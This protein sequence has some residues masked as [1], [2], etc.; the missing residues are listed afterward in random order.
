[1]QSEKSIYTSQLDTNVRPQDD[2]FGYVNNTWLAAHPI[3]DSETWWGTFM[4]L[5]DEAWANLRTLYEELQGA[6]V[7]LQTI[8]QQARD[9]YYTGMH[10]NEFEQA[11]LDLIRRYLQ[12]IDAVE[13]LSQLSELLGSFD[14]IDVPGLWRVIIDVDDKDASRHIL[15]LKQPRL[16]LPDR[17]YYLDDAQKMKDIRTAYERHSRKVYEHF[18]EL[19]KDADSLWR[20]VWEIERG[21]AEH[22]RTRAELRDVEGNYHK[23]TY[24]TLVQDYPSIDWDLFASA[25]GWETG[26]DLSVDQPE[27]FTYINEQLKSRSLDDWKI[28]MKWRFVISYYSVISERFTDLKFEFFGKVLTGAVEKMPL[29]KRVVLRIDSEMGEGVGKLYAERHFPESSKEQVRTMVE[30]I[31]AAYKDRILQLD[32]MGEETKQKALEKLANIKVLIGYPDEWRDFSALHIGRT[33]YLE[34]ILATEKFQAAYHLAK[35][36]KPTSR[37]EWLMNPQ[38]VNA[39]NDPNRLVICFPAAIIQQPFFDPK[40]PFAANMGGIGTVI[41]HELTHGFDDE[42]Y[43]FDA[44]GNV[45]KWQTDEERAAFEKRTQLV[46]DHADHFEVLPGLTLRGKLVIGESVADLGGIEISYHALKKE[47]GDKIN[48]VVVDNLTAAQLFFIS[49]AMTECTAIREERSREFALSDPHPDSHFR[50]NGI[51]SHVDAFY[52]VFNVSSNDALYRKPE[53]RAKIW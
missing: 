7:K 13:D 17:D 9:F 38:T 33:S 31:R 44:H 19:A 5:R 42:G 20:V 27:Y 51:L 6:D 4:I 15:R 3:P 22:S 47:L 24:E 28:F 49:Y 35:L 25:L 30:D 29:W 43:L 39:Y 36:N 52:D 26:S 1:M 40:A 53:D 46:I 48:D 16:T 10:F 45:N 12:Q 18:P 21:F 50:V 37:D 2:F 11:H 23:K 32:W 8:E 14:T 41:G 34:N